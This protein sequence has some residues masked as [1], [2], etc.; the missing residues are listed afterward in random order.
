MNKIIYCIL[1]FILLFI[2]IYWLKPDSSKE[3]VNSPVN[4]KND[5][6]VNE[7]KELNDKSDFVVSKKENKQTLRSE[8]LIN[9]YKEI[10]NIGWDKTA[11]KLISGDVNTLGLS[12]DE[13]QQI[14]DIVLINVDYKKTVDLFN[15]GC[16]PQSSRASFH[17]INNKEGVSENDILEKIKFYKENNMLVG[18]VD[19]YDDETN[20]KETY[21]LYD[22][23]VSF[24]YVNIIKYLESNGFSPSYDPIENQITSFTNLSMINHL[25]DNGYRA[26]NKTMYLIEKTSFKENYP[27][28]YKRLSKY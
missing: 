24:G 18:N 26:N 4:H 22:R 15:N 5:S 11:D 2:L 27:E 20:S 6:L 3:I 9:F 17:I 7:T 28:V 25:L 19:Y 10:K 14:C 1:L 12:T 23:A 8:N 21:N 16:K 13:I